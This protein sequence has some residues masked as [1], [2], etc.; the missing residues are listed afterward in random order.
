MR[1]VVCKVDNLVWA[2]ARWPISLCS[3]TFF[4]RKKSSVRQASF[5]AR[6]WGRLR[7]WTG[8]RRGEGRSTR[9]VPQL[10]GWSFRWQRDVT[11]KF[12]SIAF[13][14]IP[15]VARN[16]PNIPVII[17]QR[18]PRVPVKDV[19]IPYDINGPRPG[20]FVP[21]TLIARCWW[22]EGPRQLPFCILPH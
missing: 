11:L 2:L 19:L 14:L 1:N 10:N 4:R 17:H 16:G 3:F 6:A 13:V 21:H 20:S 7:N 18:R 8:R 15:F 5:L 12:L 9:F 22:Y